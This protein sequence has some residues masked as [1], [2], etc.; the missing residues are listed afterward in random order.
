MS[1]S[2]STS[3]LTAE[4]AGEQPLG[5]RLRGLW[6]ALT[7]NGKVTI[8]LIIV[9]LFVLVALV[10]PFF[11][12]FDANAFGSDIS[13]PPSLAHPLGTTSYGQDVL[14]QMIVGTR[15][16]VAL[17]FITGIIA[18]IISVI[19]GLVSGYFGGWIDEG[20]SVLSNVFLVLP[21]LPLAI[22][23]T[24]FLPYKGPLTIGFVLA[25]TGWSWGARVLRAQTL[26]LR[27]REFVI[28][29]KATGESS[30]RIIFFEIFPSEIGVVVAQLLGTI[31][32]VILAEAG[33]EYLGLGDLGSV[34]WGT[35]LYWAGNNDALLLGSW[36]WFVPPGLCIALLGAGLAFLNFG[37]DEIANPRLRTTFGSKAK[38]GA[39]ATG[40]HP[41]GADSNGVDSKETVVA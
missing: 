13:V 19:V 21:T 22:V 12:T 31:I 20:G 27:T 11:I 34:S 38:R 41:E 36:W 9:T 18:T 4:V 23:L 29:A 16:S 24:S 1:I 37:I 40:A 28:A 32:Y 17:G 35:M 26:S 5:A 33:L 10:G 7:S 25:I 15:V 6:H 39:G 8:G 14:A 2:S 30:W 3:P